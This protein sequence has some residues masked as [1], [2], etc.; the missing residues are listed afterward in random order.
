MAKQLAAA[1]VPVVRLGIRE[2]EARLGVHRATIWR[3]C[4][5]GRL[6]NPEYLSDRR[7]WRVDVL[8][9]FEKQQLARPPEARRPCNLGAAA[10][11]KG[12][13]EGGMLTRRNDP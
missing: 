5:D 13:R 12:E 4:R 8:E 9:A 2:V 1:L 3:M 7:T 6:P 11:P 10:K